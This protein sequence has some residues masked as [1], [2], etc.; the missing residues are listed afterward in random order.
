M[1]E[2]G[3][4]TIATETVELD[5]SS[6]STIPFDIPPGRYVQITVSD[7]GIGMDEEVQSHAFEPFFT[8]KTEGK[9]TGMGLPSVYGTVSNHRGA[10]TLESHIGKGTTFTVYLPVATPDVL[11]WHEDYD[12]LVKG[13]ATVMIVDDEETFRDMAVATLTSLGYRTITAADGAAALEYYRHAWKEVDLVILDM[14]MPE[15]DGRATFEQMRETNP[16]VKVLLCSGYS[17]DGRS[18]ELLQEGAK[19]FIEKPFRKAQLSMKVAEILGG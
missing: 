19:G 5:D 6:C 17:V 16:E 7:T 8:T 18:Q 11:P 10:V 12:R 4:L 9:G 13:S 3:E 14:I 15:L 2:G 1:P